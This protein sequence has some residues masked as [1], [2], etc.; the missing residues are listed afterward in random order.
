MA[1]P[2]TS[3]TRWPAPGLIW[4]LVL[5]AL[6]L[7]YRRS[8]LGVLWAQV[9]PLVQV[10]V[11][12]L[13]FTRVVPLGIEDYPVVALLGLLPWLS[14]Q[15]ALVTGTESVVAGKDLLRQPGFPRLALPVAAVSSALAH[16]LLAFPVALVAVVVATERL[17]VT[18]LAVVPLLAV[19]LLLCLGPALALSSVHVRFRDTV[20]I[21]GVVLVPLFYATPVFYEASR[22]DEVPALRWNPLVP[23]VEGYR[24]ALLGGTWPDPAPLL[25]VAAV[26][27]VGVALGLRAFSARAGTFLEE[28]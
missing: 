21:V 12:T 18:A 5:R 15:S 4:E 2:A 22:L 7:R 28:L 27:T 14:F 26:A 19:Q 16:H 11:L 9:T 20:S 25:L 24:D 1:A 10:L 23:I 13:I 8:A 3:L 6:R 17:P